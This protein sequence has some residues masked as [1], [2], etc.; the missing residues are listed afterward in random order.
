[1]KK[2][3][4]LINLENICII[5]L[6]LYI[7]ACS[8]WP[9]L[10]KDLGISIEVVSVLLILIIAYI[11]KNRGE[12]ETFKSKVENYRILIASIFLWL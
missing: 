10:F 7:I 8:V 1:M 9:K 4:S 5:V 2:F 11:E 3:Y 12:I 6:L